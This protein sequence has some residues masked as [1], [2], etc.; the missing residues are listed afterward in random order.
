MN[1]G[2][3]PPRAV[4][5]GGGRTSGPLIEEAAKLVQKGETFREGIG[6]GEGGGEEIFSDAYLALR[7]LRVDGPPRDTWPCLGWASVTVSL[8]SGDRRF[9]PGAERISIRKASP[10]DAEAISR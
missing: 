10:V 5:D 8:E 6:R 3:S 9:G 4:S 2:V 1:D 7:Q